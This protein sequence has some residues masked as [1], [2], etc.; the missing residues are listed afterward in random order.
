MHS[1][2]L[3]TITSDW[4]NAL[5]HER[6]ILL[7][8]P[9]QN[10]INATES[11][12]YYPPR[13]DIFNAFKLCPYHKVRVVI[14][15]QDPYHGDNQA[16]GLAFSVPEGIAIPPSLR[17][18]YKEIEADIGVPAPSSGNLVRWAEQGVLLLNSTLT[19]APH[20]AGSHQ[21]LGWEQFTD[22]VITHLSTH[23]TGMV[24]LLWGK[25]A[26]AK[27]P[28]IDTTKHLVL[29]A[30]HPSPLSAHRGFLGCRHFS[31]TNQYLIAH[32]QTPINW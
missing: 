15:G 29:R 7:Q 23:K 10:L 4:D 19:V 26:I 13:T 14:L 24:F 8:T 31:Q 12:T 3:P 32:R 9:L 16:H 6:S 21:Q 17:N 30:P 2:M 11:G 22:A 18:I 5:T 27:Q 1:S 20:K 25:F 28:L